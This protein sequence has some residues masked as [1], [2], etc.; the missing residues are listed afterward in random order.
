MKS[1]KKIKFDELDLKCIKEMPIIMEVLSSTFNKVGRLITEY[2]GDS[3]QVLRKE[4]HSKSGWRIKQEKHKNR[5]RPLTSEWSTMRIDTLENHFDIHTII[6]MR[7]MVK[8]K[9]TLEF[10]VE[11]GYYFNNTENENLNYF[12]FLLY[13]WSQFKKFGF[14]KEKSFYEKIKKSIKEFPVELSYSTDDEESIE[15]LCKEIN[16]DRIDEAYQIFKNKILI[17]F[18]KGL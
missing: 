9:P 7:K 8:N 14:I 18:I 11:L 6:I 13:R 2:A 17:P 16:V 3:E 5:F 12:Y 1:D 4:L 15:I 10:W